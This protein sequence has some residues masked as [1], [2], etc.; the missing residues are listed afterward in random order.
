VTQRIE[1]PN[2]TIGFADLHGN[3]NLWHDFDPSLPY[4]K[5]VI[6]QEQPRRGR[7]KR[8]VGQGRWICA[9]RRI[10]IGQQG[11]RKR[12]KFKFLGNGDVE[13]NI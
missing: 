4:T 3:M 11:S 5:D 9:R 12:F 7:T 1:P 13:E 8:K 2:D 10:D 6:Y